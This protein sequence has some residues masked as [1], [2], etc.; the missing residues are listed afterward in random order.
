MSSTTKWALGIIA[1]VVVVGAY[2]YPTSQ[3]VI[4]SFGSST[5][6]TTFNTAKF[7]GVVMTPTAPGTNAT[8][9]SILNS[10]SF[11]RYVT[12]VEVGCQSLGTSRTAYTGTALAALTLTIATTSTSAPGVLGNTNFVATPTTVATSTGTFVVSSSTTPV[13]GLVVPNEV[14]ASGSYMTFAFNATNTGTCTAG[15]AYIGS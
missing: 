3:T 8:T 7:A 14:W 9:S 15:V 13:A 11:D 10:D 1:A 2:F 5:V 12:R 4:Q 6:G